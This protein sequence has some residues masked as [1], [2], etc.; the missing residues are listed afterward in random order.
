MGAGEPSRIG[1]A[2]GLDVHWVSGL[3]ITPEPL[4]HREPAPHGQP[5]LTS[6]TPFTLEGPD[7]TTKIKSRE[8]MIHVSILANSGPGNTLVSMFASVPVTPERMKVLHQL[9]RGAQWQK[10]NSSL[11]ATWQEVQRIVAKHVGKSE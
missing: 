1:S 8:P 5:M 6:D 9:V 4:A 7:M 3:G 10:Q 2:C 11:N